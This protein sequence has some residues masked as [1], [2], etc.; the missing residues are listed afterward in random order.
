MYCKKCGTNAGED[1]YCPHCGANIATAESHVENFNLITAYLSMLKKYAQ[2]NGRSRRSE[3]FLAV[4]ANVIIVFVLNLLGILFTALS[5]SIG[6][7]GTIPSLI[8][9]ILLWVYCLAILVPAWAISVR[10]MHDIGKSGWHVLWQLIPYIG[11]FI[12]FWMALQDSQ[13][14]ENWYGPSPKY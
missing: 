6:L 8:I 7:A 11:S 2:F 1:R 13:R 12:F 9:G 3:Y 14:T 10:R 4:V 5:E